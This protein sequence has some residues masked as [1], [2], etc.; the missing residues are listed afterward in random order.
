MALYFSGG[1]ALDLFAGSGALGIEGLSRGM[2]KV[3]MIDKD[4]QAIQTIKKNVQS[5]ELDN[6]VEIYRNDAERALKAL[7]KRDIHFDYIF[8][9]PPY[10]RQ[11]LEVILHTIEKSNLLKQQGMIIV[12]HDSDLSLILIFHFS[13]EYWGIRM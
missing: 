5:C 12:E 1:I 8:L 3:I 6:Q 11:K 10:H 9:D 7:I 4:R 2:E 13:K